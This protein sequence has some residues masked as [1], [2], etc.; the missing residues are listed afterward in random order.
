MRWLSPVFSPSLRLVGAL[1][2]SL[3]PRLS[4][5]SGRW[6]GFGYVLGP[7]SLVAMCP[8]LVYFFLPLLSLPFPLLILALAL[9]PVECI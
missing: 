4:G 7:R 3:H 6:R 1:A 2:L 9:P 5:E 8:C